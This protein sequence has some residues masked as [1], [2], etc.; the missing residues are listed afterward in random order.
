MATSNVAQ[1]SFPVDILQA[2][3]QPSYWRGLNP[4]LT[5]E[6]TN[7]ELGSSLDAD[8]TEK[9]ALDVK[10][11]GYFQAHDVCPIRV[12]RR[13]ADAIKRF[14]ELQCPVVFAFVYDEFW[15]IFRQI[16]PLMGRI[17]GESFQQLPD[18]WAWYV[19][20]ATESSG[21]RP[22]RDKGFQALRP[23]GTPL[24]LT[25][26]VPLTDTTPLNGCIY[27][28]PSHLDPPSLYENQE[29]KRLPNNMQ[30]VRAIPATAGSFLGWN[31][32]VLHWGGR[33]SRR[34]TEPRI[35]VAFEFQCGDIPPYNQPLLDPH[36]SPPFGTRLRL[37]GKQILQYRHMY[38]FSDALSALGESLAK[39][40]SNA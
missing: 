38:G 1:G 6:S 2:V 22:H 28:V 12:V 30:D 20:P 15:S 19:D 35:S 7:T 24:S 11:E 40:E 9:L 29:D 31:Q 16:T 8:E 37:I 26:W 17:L 33:A 25:V 4:Q 5:I 14:H 36:R 32:A 34:A 27:L 39:F 21:W 13:M 10:N 23:D 18:F 3:V